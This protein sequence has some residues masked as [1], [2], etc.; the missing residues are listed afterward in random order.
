MEGLVLVVTI[1]HLLVVV[2][3]VHVV[4]VL[5]QLQ[6]RH[7]RLVTSFMPNRLSLSTKC[8]LHTLL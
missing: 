5:T 8:S 6:G 4:A 3:E 7:G 1:L 2:L